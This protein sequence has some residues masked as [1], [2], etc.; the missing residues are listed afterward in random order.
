[1]LIIKLYLTSPISVHRVK[2]LATPAVYNS[3]EVAIVFSYQPKMMKI[4]YIYIDE[5]K[6]KM[7]TKNRKEYF[8]WDENITYKV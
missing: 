2:L 5:T 1:L 8:L 6:T 7:N 4:F 3:G